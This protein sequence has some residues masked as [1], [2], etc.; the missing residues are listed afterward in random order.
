MPASH[1]EPSIS[2]VNLL[3]HAKTGPNQA[4][5]NKFPISEQQ[6][7]YLDGEEPGDAPCGEPLHDPRRDPQPR[8][9]QPVVPTDGRPRLRAGPRRRCGPEPQGAR[10]AMER[11]PPRWLRRSRAPAWV[12]RASRRGE[13]R[14]EKRS[15][16]RRRRRGG[17]GAE[18]TA[19]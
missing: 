15:P 14:G 19:E 10:R 7:G 4:S 2:S 3:L 5:H 17:G 18:R 8:D 12:E 13:Q 9:L 1:M 6:A 11:P 16:P